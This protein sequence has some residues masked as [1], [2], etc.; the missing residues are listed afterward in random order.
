M[1]GGVCKLK[2]L[3]VMFHVSV[4]DFSCEIFMEVAAA[5]DRNKRISKVTDVKSSTKLHVGEDGT[6]Q[7][8]D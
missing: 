7:I 6:C 4:L 3:V 1:K 8:F 2:L 5:N